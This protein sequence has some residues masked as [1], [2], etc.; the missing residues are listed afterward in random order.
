MQLEWAGF[1]VGVIV[2]LGTA[3]SVLFT[4]VVPRSVPSRLA[5]VIDRVD[6]GF[7]VIIARRAKRYETKDKILA[8]QGPLSL[9]TQLVT[10]VALFVLAFGLILWPLIHSTFAEALRQSGSSF[11][12]LGLAGERLPGASTVYFL[13]SG[14]GLVVVALQIGY[15]PTLYSAFNR[16][17]TLVTMLDT[18]AGAPAWGPEILARHQA[19]G[20]LDNMPDFYAEWERWAAD[21]AESH[22]TY[23]VLIGFRSP[24]PFRSWVIAL[25]AVLDSAALYLALAPDRAPS[26][27]R[28]CLRMGFTAFREVAKEAYLEFNTD[29]Y[30]DDPVQLTFGEFHDGVQRLLEVGFV[31]ERTADEAWPHFRGWRVNYESIAYALA[32]KLLVTPG[33]WAG[34]RKHIREETMPLRRPVDR[35]PKSP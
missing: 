8:L 15:L 1:A 17:E 16:R 25:L 14:T 33:R 26:E 24:D 22:T 21:L 30:P 7:F 10:W 9:L 11:F 28:L 3:M 35:K 5:A 34:P 29:P 6:R 20:I 18:R 2:V 31:L 23:P 12:T 19:V 4:L 13:A 32:D 27:A